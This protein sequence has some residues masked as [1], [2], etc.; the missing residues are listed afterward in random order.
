MAKSNNQAKAQVDSKV[1]KEI[2]DNLNQP[3]LANAPAEKKIGFF[4]AMM[5]AMGSSIGAGIFFKAKGVLEATS[6]SLVMAIIAWLIAAFTVIS[7]A[8]ALVEVSSSRNDNLGV[9]GWCKTFNSRIIYKAS[10][11]FMIYIYLPLTFFFMP[12]Y[13]IQSIMDAGPAFGWENGRLVGSGD[14]DWAIWMVIAIAIASFFMFLS[15]LSAKAGNIM[16]KIILGVKFIPLFV[17]IILGF[18]I[19]GW[20]GYGAHVS[21]GPQLPPEFQESADKI[22]SGYNAYDFGFT[23]GGIGIFMSVGAIFFAYDG[24]YVTAGMQT[25]MKE[26][27]KTPIAIVLGLGAVTIIYLLIAISMSLGGNGGIGGFF[28]FLEDRDCLWIF[29]ALNI[30]I[31]IGVMGIINGFAMWAPRFI[32]DLMRENELPFSEKYKD[33]L[34]VSRPLVGVLYLATITAPIVIVFNLIGALAYYDG[35]QGDYTKEMGRLLTFCDLMGTWTSVLV[36]MFIVFPIGGCLKN[37]KTKKIQTEQKKYFKWSACV[38]IV[39]ISIVLVLVFVDA[40]YNVFIL[41][42]LAIPNGYGPFIEAKIGGNDGITARIMKL[43]V[44]FI[45]IGIMFIPTIIEDAINKKKS[46]SINKQEEIEVATN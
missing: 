43:V 42:N 26:P 40:F 46:L 11:N 28:N 27:Q 37:R 44:L 10:K 16:N 31:A 4:S 2:K 38:S 45:F 34:N 9:I 29:G 35:Y 19:A 33:K 7:M 17:T 6:G 32:E 41:I 8:L 36:F 12:L 30:L 3:S 13:V 18:V 22:S 25:E 5:I 23:S 14:Y 1:S 39:I 20:S 24:F 21:A 15:G